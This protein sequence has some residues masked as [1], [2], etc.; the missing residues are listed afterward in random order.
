[1]FK[2]LLSVFVLGILFTL[3]IPLNTYAIQ[4]NS[5]TNLAILPENLKIGVE[6][7]LADQITGE[8]SLLQRESISENEG[9]IIESI[10]GVLGIIFPDRNDSESTLIP[11]E[12]EPEVNLI[13]RI[14]DIVKN[15]FS[16]RNNTEQELIPE[17]LPIPEVNE[18][19]NERGGFGRFLYSF[20]S[21][22][23]GAIFNPG[24]GILFG[25]NIGFS[26]IGFIGMYIV[27]AILIYSAPVKTVNIG[28]KITQSWQDLL[29]SFAVG[30][31]I[32]IAIPVPLFILAMSLVGIPLALLIIAILI[33]LISFGTLWA[34]IAIG[35][36]L[37]ELAKY[38]DNQRY[39]SL[40]IGRII[41]VLIKIIPF[42]G[43]IYTMILNTT[44]VGAVVRMK[45]NTLQVSKDK[46][47]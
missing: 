6:R 25:L 5:S 40:L 45:Y 4:S 15:F 39:L 35:H 1:M 30:F 34:E 37:L 2:K 17:L 47:K 46:K 18:P 38:K 43:P 9:N 44:I 8:D 3:L 16:N 10:R 27:G 41:T 19:N 36:K 11:E 33:F 23:N 13:G 32:L 22:N 31:V 28:K 21:N 7:I 26:I 14:V 24:N 12:S 29:I 42:I 20:F